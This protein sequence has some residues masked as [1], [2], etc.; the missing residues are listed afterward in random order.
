M[1]LLGSLG[2]HITMKTLALLT[3]VPTLLWA[4]TSS[5]TSPSAFTCTSSLDCSLNGICSPKTS[6]CACDPG[7]TSP[8]CGALDL[9]PAKLGTGYNL[10]SV[11]TSS[12]GSKIVHDP[13][14]HHLFHLFLAEFTHSCGLDYWSP[15]SRIVH[16]TSAVGPAGPY[17][18]DSEVVGTFAHNPTVIYSPADSKYLLYYIGCPQTVN[19]TCTSPQ[20]TCGPGNTIN[21]ESG[22]S[23]A[24]ST[25]LYTWTTHGQI[26][27]G[28]NDDAWDADITNPSP[29]PLFGTGGVESAAEMLLVYRG[30]PYNCSGDE[31]I[32]LSTASSFLGPYEKIRPPDPLFPEGNEDPFVWRDKRGHWHMLLHSLEPEGGFGSGPKVGRHAFAEK[33]DG[34]WTFDNQ[35]LAFSTHVEFEGSE[36]KDY[37]R[38]ERPQL[39]FSE[40]GK[41][42]P[43]YLTTG[44]QEVNSPMSYSFIQ[45]IEGAKE[46]EESLGF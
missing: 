22:I 45:P 16:A 21:G 3:S 4:V 28:A 26:L 1:Y 10:T 35:T 9:L 34:P 15:Y 40:D 18:F 36:A 20:F 2:Q 38:R 24:S 31:L 27:Q 43:L 13:Q 32:S 6:T 41:M 17:T 7:W 44:V 39:F 46:Y 23:V 14:N 8:S 30:C 37:Y 19:P 5:S 12:W 11:N 33:L 25:D 29:F 42:R